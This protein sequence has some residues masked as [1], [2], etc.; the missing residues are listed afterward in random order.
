MI[1][2]IIKNII[3]MYLFT[4]TLFINTLCEIFYVT[5]TKKGINKIK[6]AIIASLYK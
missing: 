1:K 5:K 3:N 4:Y 2:N 6:K